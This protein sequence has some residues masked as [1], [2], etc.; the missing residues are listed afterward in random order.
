MLG[1]DH[2]EYA[3]DSATASDTVEK[4]SMV[5]LSGVPGTIHVSPSPVFPGK[6]VLEAGVALR[7]GVGFAKFV[8]LEGS[9]SLIT[10]QP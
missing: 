5:T 2:A 1:T 4:P 7:F 3:A 6:I 10:Y 8:K 9:Q